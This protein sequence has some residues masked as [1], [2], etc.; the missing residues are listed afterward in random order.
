MSD[1]DDDINQSAARPGMEGPANRGGMFKE[2]MTHVSKDAK[3]GVETRTDVD[4]H[5]VAHDARDQDGTR[6]GPRR[7]VSPPTRSAFGPDSASAPAPP[8]A[9][10]APSAPAAPSS[11][12]SGKGG[13]QRTQAIEDEADKAG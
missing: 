13:R 5:P 4:L 10:P 1:Y 6:Q 8:K 11:P 12:G 7:A 9:P 3:T 2:T